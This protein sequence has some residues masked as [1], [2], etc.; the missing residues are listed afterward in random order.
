[1]NTIIKLIGLVAILTV[2]GVIVLAVLGRPVPDG[3][4]TTCAGSCI[5]SLAAIA[6]PGLGTMPPAVKPREM[7]QAEKETE[8]PTP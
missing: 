3:L 7:P 8:E 1:M 6:S 5:T 4:I 2:V